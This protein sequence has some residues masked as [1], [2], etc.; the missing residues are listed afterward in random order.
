MYIKQTVDKQVGSASGH[1]TLT[2]KVNNHSAS[3]TAFQLR[4]PTVNGA[5]KNNEESYGLKASGI[6]LCDWFITRFVFI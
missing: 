6:A 2:D 5:C 3:S 1:T 4:K